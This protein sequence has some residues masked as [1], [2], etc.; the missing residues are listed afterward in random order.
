MDDAVR[1]IIFVDV[2]GTH[3]INYNKQGIPFIHTTI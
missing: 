3:Y 2:G 1:I